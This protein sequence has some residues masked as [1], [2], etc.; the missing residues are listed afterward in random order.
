MTIIKTTTQESFDYNICFPPPVL[1]KKDFVKRYAAGEFGNASPTWN[2]WQ[3]VSASNY[4]GMVHLRNRVAGGPTWYNIPANY[5]EPVLYYVTTL[6]H[7]GTAAK[8]R[9]YA[10][11]NYKLKYPEKPENIYFSG[12]APTP[13]TLLQG[14]VMRDFRDGSLY[15]YYSQVK[16]PMRDALKEKAAEASGIVAD[17]LLR[18]YLCPNSREWLYVLLDRY[19]NHVVEFSA[20][21]EKW[22][23]LAPL[24]NTCFWEVRHY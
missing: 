4:Q 13:K 1:T 9:A 5:V 21:G 11:Y 24:F 8:A 15:L 19:P 22:G 7:K 23:T 10:D 16:K 18:R 12:M 6:D 2:T 14:E 20:Y 17:H 3:E